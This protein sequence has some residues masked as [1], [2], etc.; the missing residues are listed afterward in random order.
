M[1]RFRS[2]LIRAGLNAMYVAGAHRWLQPIYGGVGTIF[3]LHHVRPARR[4]A[5]QP[6]RH[7]EI[8]PDFLR[9]TLTHLRRHDIDIV[10]L[11]EM[12]RRLEVRDFARRFAC[13]T[14]DDGYRDNRDYA[15]PVMRE[16]GAPMT[17][18][19]AGDFAGGN[20]H[21][22]WIALE[23][24][25]AA[26]DAIEAPV[27]GATT[28]LDTTTPDAKIACF[29]A[30]H[31]WLRGMPDDR[32][33][34]RVASAFY[35]HYGID[36]EAISAELCMSWPELKD[37]ARDP[38]VT[39]GAHSMSHCNLAKVSRDDAVAEMTRSRALL[40]TQTGQA[41]KHFAFP[42]GDRAA[43][44]AREFALAREL[45]FAT[46][47]TTRPGVVFAGN[48]DHMTAL[49]RLSLNGLYQEESYLAVLTS[50]AATAMANGF[51]R[52]TP[53]QVA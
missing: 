43:A 39:L 34:Q 36:M 28:R 29:A 48:A 26:N 7:L 14:L 24:L 1:K 50:G 20:G 5:F 2:N 41:V 13:F 32:D 16:F 46:A 44:G 53:A 30:L 18:F 33:M 31:D 45:G 11:D 15:L 10:T 49:P 37:F 4:D 8:T 23:R 12:T 17:V 35:A 27:D 42:Y 9:T 19:V 38:L 47:M 21:P 22:W 52:F 6:N 25:I 3:T 40:E 51:R